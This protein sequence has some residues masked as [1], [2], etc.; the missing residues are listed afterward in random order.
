MNEKHIEAAASQMGVDYGEALRQISRGIAA[1]WCSWTHGGGRIERDP[2]GR[3]NW[4]CSKCGRWA[5]P[6]SHAD[7]ANL[8]DRRIKSVQKSNNPTNGGS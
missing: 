3:V 7:E 2:S 4:Q 1:E 8:L 6:V 5:E